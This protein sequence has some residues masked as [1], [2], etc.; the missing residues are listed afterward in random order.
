MGVFMKRN[1]NSNQTETPPPWLADLQQFSLRM[2]AI[3]TRMSELVE[4]QMVI[5]SLPPAEVRVAPELS[6]KLESIASALSRPQEPPAWPEELAQLAQ[7]PDKLV[8]SLARTRTVEVVS[9]GW[10]AEMAAFGEQLERISGQLGEVVERARYRREPLRQQGPPEGGSG[11]P[12][13]VL[14]PP[15]H[16]SI[17]LERFNTVALDGNTV[18]ELVPP[19]P[20]V[21]LLNLVNLGPG[22]VYVRANADPSPGDPHSET[23]PK[24]ALDNQIHTPGTLRVV[25]DPIGSSISV[26]LD[27]L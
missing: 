19:E 13:I 24:G 15:Q 3:A 12:V 25:A 9:T 5:A 23:L 18:Y 11:S 17:Q 10:P 22:S 26:R 21:H 1:G 8:E 14:D 7:L 27:Y 20:N 4:Q 2:E 6:A 16:A